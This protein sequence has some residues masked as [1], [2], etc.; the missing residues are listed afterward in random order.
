MKTAILFIFSFLRA[1]IED[2]LGA[3]TFASGFAF[4]I[5]LSMELKPAAIVPEV[6]P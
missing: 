6:H 1:L 2:S 3:E 5:L 4:L